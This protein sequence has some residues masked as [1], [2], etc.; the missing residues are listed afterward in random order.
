MKEL[1]QQNSRNLIRGPLPGRSRGSDQWGG[2]IGIQRGADGGQVSGIHNANPADKRAPPKDGLHPDSQ[3]GRSHEAVAQSADNNAI[4]L[5]FKNA[6]MS[7]E[8][9]LSKQ[10][11]DFSRVSK[12]IRLIERQFFRDDAEIGTGRFQFRCQPADG[13]GGVNHTSKL[14]RFGAKTNGKQWSLPGK[15]ARRSEK[16]EKNAHR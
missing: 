16:G 4:R 10:A 7:G 1:F 5:E 8:S 11:L 15:S 14:D 13:I 12:R 6:L 9:Y 2:T 3:G